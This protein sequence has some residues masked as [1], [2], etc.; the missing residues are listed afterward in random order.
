MTEPRPLKINPEKFRATFERMVVEQTNRLKP[1]ALVNAVVK[2]IENER[3]KLI[4]EMLG[5]DTNWHKPELNTNSDAGKLLSAEV[6]QL[7]KKELDTWISKAWE[8]EKTN[9]EKIAATTFRRWMRNE[10]TDLFYE[11]LQNQG[12]EIV[13]TMVNEILAVEEE[14]IRG[15]LQLLPA[16]KPITLKEL[17]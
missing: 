16:K 1:E 2:N 12:N 7:A 17:P 9:I 14:R 8:D 6:H 15:A 4:L 5:F 11:Q 3:Q 10:L 13:V